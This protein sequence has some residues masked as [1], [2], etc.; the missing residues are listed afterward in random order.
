MVRKK[1]TQN[2]DLEPKT[3]SHI[4]GR[5][6][7]ASATSTPD[8]QLGFERFV[9]IGLLF[10]FLRAQSTSDIMKLVIFWLAVLAVGSNQALEAGAKK[11]LCP[12]G[13]NTCQD[14]PITEEPP[15]TK[16]KKLTD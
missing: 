6:S 13:G 10:F 5:V 14:T 3:R 8:C 1:D 4:T 9:S 7:S 2:T 12:G 15:Y 11:G 16:V